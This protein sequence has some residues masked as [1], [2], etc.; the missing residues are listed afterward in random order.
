LAACLNLWSQWGTCSIGLSIC[1]PSPDA[2]PAQDVAQQQPQVFPP[3]QV[4]AQLQPVPNPE[5]TAPNTTQPEEGR[6]FHFVS[7]PAFYRSL[8]FAN[9]LESIW[10]GFGVG[11]GVLI[12]IL[13]FAKRT[14]VINFIVH[15]NL[16]YKMESP[17]ADIELLFTRSQRVNWYGRAIF[18]IT[19]QMGMTDQQLLLVRRYWLGRVV[20]FDSLRRKKQNELALLHL[21][22]AAKT[23]LGSKGEKPL[24]QIISFFRAL[25]F[26]IFFLLRAAISFAIGF[27]Y[28][29]VTIAKLVRGWLIESADLTLLMESKTA[30]EETSRYLKEYLLLAETFDGREDL[31]EPSAP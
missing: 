26:M 20:A 8:A 24:A 9:L 18:G 17:S 23:E 25:F 1:D 13:A 2:A 12:V 3:P 10:T 29:R 28:I 31:F 6:G 30:I 21:Q 19:A 22:L 11:L 5:P 15:G 4:Q 27:F 14:V 16:P 7:D